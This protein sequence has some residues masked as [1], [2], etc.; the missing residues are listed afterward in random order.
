MEKKSRIWTVPNMLSF[1]RLACL[2][3]ILIF[4]TGGQ[5]IS[6]LVFIFLG[7]ASDFLDGWIARRFD[8]GSDLGR[9]MD[10]L[11]DKLNILS[12]GLLL[13]LSPL[14]HFPLWYFL[15]L[16]LRELS[17]LI[18]GLTVIRKQKIVLEANIA[19]KRSAFFTGVCILLYILG[20]QPYASI[21]LWIAFVLALYSTYTYLVVFLK[22]VK[23]KRRGVRGGA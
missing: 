22:Q 3:P 23:G 7:F 6:A 14:Y 1:F 2:V 18:G 10:P 4:L 8:Q 5:R 15:F 21:M 9:M 19:G 13:V 20:W 12:V 17:V 16:V 11:I